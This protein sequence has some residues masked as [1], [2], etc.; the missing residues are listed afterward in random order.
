MLK[1]I[2]LFAAAATSAFAM[3]SAQININDKDLELGARLDMGQ[4]NHAVEPDTVFLGAKFLKADGENSDPKI[5]NLEE[6]YEVNFLMLREISNSGLSMGLG[7]KMNYTQDFVSIPLGIEARYKLPIS[8]V[9][10]FYLGGSFYYAPES[11]AMKDAHSFQEYRFHLD[12]EVIKNANVTM[13]YRS[14]ETNYE[15]NNHRDDFTYNKS[16]YIGFKFLF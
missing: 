3:H 4:F 6:F 14:L 16:A 10:P 9:V 7:V 5:E 1:K 15:V 8:D 12:I 13:G 11:L 2:T